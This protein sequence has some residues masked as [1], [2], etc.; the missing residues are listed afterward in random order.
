MKFIDQT[1]DY[2]VDRVLDRVDA[3]RRPLNINIVGSTSTTNSE[4]R[5][6]AAEERL[7]RARDLSQHQ[8]KATRSFP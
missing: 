4:A 6:V 1:V 7:A 8:S 2:L 5:V 3:R